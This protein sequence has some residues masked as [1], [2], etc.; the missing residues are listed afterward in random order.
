VRWP[1]GACAVRVE[2]AAD[3]VH[4]LAAR[5]DEALDGA[6]SQVA[7]VAAFVAEGGDERGAGAPGRAARALAIGA[8]APRL[9]IAPSAL[10]VR[11][12]GRAPALFADGRALAWTLSLSHHGR[13][14][15]FA[16][17]PSVADA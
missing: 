4:A 12:A 16:A 10:A 1:G 7:R 5:D 11:R 3:C 9:G 17:L 8:L 14:V 15:A 6:R 2:R 13:F